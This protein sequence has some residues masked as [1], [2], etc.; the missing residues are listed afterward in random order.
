M[1][2]LT[3]AAAA[4]DPAER[5]RGQG[6][7]GPGVLAPTPAAGEVVG[8]ASGVAGLRWMFP[9]ALRMRQHPAAAAA[10]DPASN[11]SGGSCSSVS[12]SFLF[13]VALVS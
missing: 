11:A 2:G 8:E 6:R 4:E 10:P 7:G 13:V 12:N 1:Q 3:A 5:A 9:A